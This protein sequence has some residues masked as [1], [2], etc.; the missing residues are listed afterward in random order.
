MQ[1]EIRCRIKANH[2]R[3]DYIFQKRLHKNTAELLQEENM[4]KANL[5]EANVGPCQLSMMDLF[6]KI[7]KDF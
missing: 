6:A 4:K 3:K 5:P 7:L 2:S 1:K